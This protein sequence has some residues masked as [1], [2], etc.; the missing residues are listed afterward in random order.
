MASKEVMELRKTGKNI[1]AYEMAVNDYQAT[2]E[3]IWAKRALAWCLYDGLKDNAFFTN[4]EFFL[5]KLREIQA[6][7]IAADETMFWS[8]VAWPIGA[9]IRDCSKL[10]Y[11]P[12]EFL[13]ILFDIIREMPFVKPDKGYS[14]LLCAVNQIKEKWNRY[15]EFCDWWGFDNFR[16]EDYECEVLSNGRKMPVSTVEATYLAY[17]KHLIS[18][19]DKDAITLFIPKMQAL[20]E[21]HQEMQY[22]DYYIGKMLLSLGNTGE[23]T[24]NSILPFVRKK[25]TEFWAWQLLAEA[26]EKDDDKCMAC[27]LRAVNCHTQEQFLVN[28]YFILTQAFKQLNYYA[29]ARYYLDK[30]IQVKENTQTHI[31][32]DARKM[33]NERWYIESAGKEPSYHIDYMS[34]TN[35]IL[36]HDIAE[37]NVVISFVNKD[38]K[39]ANVI[40]GMGKEGY[41]KYERFLK[42]INVG[43][44]VKLRIKDITSERR[45]NIYSATISPE[46]VETD[47]YKKIN[48]TVASNKANT[49]YFA[50]SETTSCFIPMDLVSKNQLNV[51]DSITAYALYSY[52]KKKESWNWVCVKIIK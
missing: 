32:N 25:Q 45:I 38:K 34:I 11:L 31:S 51:G 6:L 14:V 8:K 47:F 9:I 12:E 5:D 44:S 39:I 3:D 30:Y 26:L 41:F 46:T 27:L 18:K 28:L 48:A 20:A 2:P 40:Y 29:D 1:E 50:N 52:N 23:E 37:T 49:A 7:N 19:K 42:K 21:S 17:A 13:S 43:D 35:D 33:L 22:P 15:T 36:F 16:Q 10:Q 4:N 24:L